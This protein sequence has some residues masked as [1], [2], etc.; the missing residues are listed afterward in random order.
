MLSV[1]SLNKF[2]IIY[3][4]VLAVLGQFLDLLLGSGT[5]KTYLC[6]AISIFYI[7]FMIKRPVFGRID[8]LAIGLFVVFLH[9]NQY[10][11]DGNTYGI[12]RCA[13]IILFLIV[14]KL[15]DE[16]PEKY[17]YYSFPAYLVHVLA[18]IWLSFD[19]VSYYNLVLPLFPAQRYTLISQ[20]ENGQI[21][22]LTTHYSTNGMYIACAIILL[23]VYYL[24]ES[25]KKK[26]KR[27]FIFLCL[28][29]VAVLITGKRAHVI[30]T[31][32]AMLITYNAYAIKSKRTRIFKI[33]SIIS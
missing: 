10:L 25:N 30:F 17:L 7:I 27:Y 6:L 26:K 4:V 31:A 16:W 8:F 9:G 13:F 29:I 28:A 15:S 20:Y 12:V 5:P 14:C 1:K 19:S 11:E 2:T 33:F 23:F 18:T 32:A 3:L 24:N 21:A 22:G